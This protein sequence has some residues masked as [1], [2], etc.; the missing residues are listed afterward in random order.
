VKTFAK[1][2]RLPKDPDQE[3]APWRASLY[4]KYIIVGNVTFMTIKS[5][6][7]THVCQE[8]G[9]FMKSINSNEKDNFNKITFK[10]GIS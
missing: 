10:G 6:K 8:M 9:G 2:F 7:Y 3:I 4:C 5:T 1:G